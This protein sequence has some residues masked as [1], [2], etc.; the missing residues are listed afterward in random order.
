MK[1]KRPVNL[2]ISTIQLPLAAITS[3]T[4][5]ITGVILF[6]GIAVL[7]WLFDLSL[8]SEAGFA[9]VQDMLSATWVKT[10]VFALMAALTYHL[11]AGVKHLL[12]DLG[13]GESKSGGPLG[14]R[15]VIVI[16]LALIVLQ[17]VV[18]W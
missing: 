3:I 14:A 6:G 18:L 17:G 12:M 4:H 7:L 1:D 2:D 8:S 11:V 16:S 9:R 10:I 15:L 13:I 5:R